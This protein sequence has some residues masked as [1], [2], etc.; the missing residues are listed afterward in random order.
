VNG[1]IH[2]HFCAD[3]FDCQTAVRAVNRTSFFVHDV[4]GDTSQ[5]GSIGIVKSLLHW[6]DL[7]SV[8]LLRCDQM[9]LAVC[10]VLQH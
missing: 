2:V 3:C 7:L 4:A 8:V 6:S 1:R 5:P 10:L 9:G